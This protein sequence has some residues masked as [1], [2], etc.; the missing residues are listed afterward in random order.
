MSSHN[1]SIHPTILR[2]KY[3]C[4]NFIGSKLPC[5]ENKIKSQPQPS[6]AMQKRNPCALK[7]QDTNYPGIE[8]R[9]IQNS[10]HVCLGQSFIKI[11]NHSLKKMQQKLYPLIS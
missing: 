4:P 5:T 9:K 3:N 10:A 7:S 2:D 8:Q 11:L 6:Q 1:T